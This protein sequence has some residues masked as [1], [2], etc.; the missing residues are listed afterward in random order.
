MSPTTA[1]PSYI[2][3]PEFRVEGELPEYSR[4]AAADERI[5]LAQPQAPRPSTRTHSEYIFKSERLELNLGEKKWPIKV[6]AY[7]WKD[8]VK[9]TVLVKDFKAVTRIT[10]T[11]GTML[12]LRMIGMFT[13]IFSSKAHVTPA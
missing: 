7:G 12:R 9:G 13:G 1:P 2:D 4:N 3:P 11:V 6:P 10:I 5:M 8:T